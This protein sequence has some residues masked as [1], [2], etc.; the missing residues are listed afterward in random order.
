[1]P[2]NIDLIARPFVPPALPPTSV[3][4]SILPPLL[5][6]LWICGCLGVLVCW[7]VRWR[8]VQTAVRL[9]RPS[10]EGREWEALRRIERLAGARRPTRLVAS[11]S[12]MEPG[13]FGIFRPVLML[14]AGVVQRLDGHQLDAIL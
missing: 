13:V 7:S 4:P 3:T 1:I 12:S 11:D 9:A 8:R 5:Q 10:T 6:C 14:P 2:A